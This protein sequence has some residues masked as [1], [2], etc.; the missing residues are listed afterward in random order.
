VKVGDEVLL[1][2]MRSGA[3]TEVIKPIGRKYIVLVDIPREKFCKLTFERVTEYVI[4]DRIYLNPQDYFDSLRRSLLEHKIAAKA[5]QGLS[6]VT[7]ARL[8]NIALQLG[9]M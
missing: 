1:V 9:V 6:K 7:L 5:R 4:S 3:T 2:S 8:E